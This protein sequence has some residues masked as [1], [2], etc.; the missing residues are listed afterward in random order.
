MS[1]ETAAWNPATGNL[2]VSNDS[3]GTAGYSHLTWFAYDVATKA[4]VDSFTL[5]SPDPVPADEFPR[6]LAFS[7][8]GMTAYVGLFGTKYSR[9][10]KFTKSSMAA[11]FT[12]DF[13]SGTANAEWGTFY[14]DP[15]TGTPEETVVAVP[16]ANVPVPLTGGGNYA[17]VL[18]DANASFTGSAVAVAGLVSLK[19][20]SIEADVFCYVN[21][22][23]SG[24]TGLVVYAD[25]VRPQRD[26]YKMRA[27]FDVSNRINFSGLKS[28]P[29]TFQPLFNVNFSGTVYPGGYPTS[30]GW[31]K[32][33]I[34][35]HT[36]GTSKVGFWCY[37]DSQLL[38]GCPIYDTA[39]AVTAGKFGLY[40]FQQDADGIAAYFDNIAVKQLEP[41]TSVEDFDNPG[42]PEEHYLSQNYPNPFNPTTNI[43]YKLKD[44]QNVSLII[45]DVIGEKVKT[46]VSQYQSAGQ[47]TITWNG[48]NDAGY[49]IKSGIYL[50]TLRAGDVL[51]SK[52]M[53]MLK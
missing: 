9:I 34:E 35:V 1:I 26:F 12:E 52:K 46:L 3:R 11:I 19:D 49:K 38:P 10:Y 31:H 27:D 33:K 5:P 24:Y 28:D 15:V 8:D 14:S 42:I 7:P 17:G 32:M 41:V 20:Y 43:S 48:Q 16:M 13:E 47:Y 39:A 44:A 37:F 50:Y 2:W 6:G 23:P 36:L 21:P 53:L 29:N 51:E 4:L 40:S 18:Q 25:S 22:T 30:D 45:Y